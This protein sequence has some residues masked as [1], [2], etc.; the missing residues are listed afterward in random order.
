MKNGLIYSLITA[1]MFVTLEPVSKLI[2]A[3]VNPFA[4]TLWRFIISTVIL[5]PY[6]FSKIKK[7]NLKITRNDLT[8]MALL[9][10]LCVCFSMILLQV[11]VKVSDNPALIA[12]IFSSNSVFTIVMAMLIMKDKLTK[13]KAIA[14]VFCVCGVI[15]C[16]DF[17]N[18]GTNLL[19]VVMA[20]LA[21][22]SFSLYSVLSQKYMTKLGGPVQMCF[23]FAFGSMV[24]FIGLLVLGID[25]VPDFTTKNILVLLYL[26]LFVTGVGYW[27]YF[28]AIEK[29]GA[30]MASF[31]FFLKPILTPFCTF[32]V[33]GIAL[34]P[35]V[36]LA[37]LLIV[38][39]SYFAVYR[40]KA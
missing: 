28:K 18:G 19:S 10:I 25:I 38:C 20:V 31:A 17:S 24:L 32:F 15:A 33:N 2:A 11:A 40:K 37:V 12:I 3:D 23:V 14:I 1:L 9:G 29:G 34:S 16:A 4:M 8:R 22:A 35:K 21:A 7:N 6:A 39:G 26:G 13:N 5:M 30:I 27:S 36:F